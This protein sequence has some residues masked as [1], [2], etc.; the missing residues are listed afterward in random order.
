[1]GVRA[2][3]ALVLCGLTIYVI[4]LVAP[5]FGVWAI[6]AGVAANVAFAGMVFAAAIFLAGRRGRPLQR[7]ADA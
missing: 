6:A 3:G 2:A 5:P 1:M 4:V 7:W